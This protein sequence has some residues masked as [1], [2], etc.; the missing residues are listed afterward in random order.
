MAQKKNRLK[1]TASVMALVAGLAGM[2]QA[3]DVE[4]TVV[5]IA[6]LVID[7]VQLEAYTAAVK[8][9]MEE[10]IRVEPGVLAIYSVAEKGK[11]N[12]LRFFEVYAN[13]EAYR[14][15]LESPH[16]KKYVAV[17]QPMIQSR[18]LIETVPVQLS[19]K[20]R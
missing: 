13:D 11:P 3:Q 16:F 15:H 19:A 14:A 5:R 9:E 4:Q 1:A 10:S 18:K 20:G 8:E 7:P 17:T 12:S 6:E 2:A